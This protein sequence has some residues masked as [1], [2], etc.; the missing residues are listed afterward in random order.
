MKNIFLAISLTFKTFLYSQKYYYIATLESQIVEG[1]KI[2]NPN[3]KQIKLIIDF[4]NNILVENGVKYSIGSTEKYFNMNRDLV[5]NFFIYN[6][7]MRKDACLIVE[8]R[9]GLFF[10]GYD[11]LKDAKTYNILLTQLDSAPLKFKK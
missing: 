5:Y 7:K 2:K 9:E 1:R 10:H 3:T 11:S 8:G 4:N 6:N